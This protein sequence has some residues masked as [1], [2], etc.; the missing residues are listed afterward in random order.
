MA[1]KEKPV[2][3]VIFKLNTAEIQFF[4]RY[5]EDHPLSEIIFLFKRAHPNSL[6]NNH[7]WGFGVGVC[8]CCKNKLDELTTF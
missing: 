5:R 6:L 3:D 8:V 4:I 1:A 7:C 2:C